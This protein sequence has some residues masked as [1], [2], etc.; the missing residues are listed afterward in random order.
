ME[1]EQRNGGGTQLLERQ[2]MVSE[3]PNFGVKAKAS[4]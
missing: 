1:K 4:T 2:Q 3:Y